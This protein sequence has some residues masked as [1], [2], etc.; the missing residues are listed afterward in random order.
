MTEISKIYE[1]QSVERRWYDFWLKHDCFQA[2]PSRVSARRPAYSIVIPPPN[3]TRVVHSGHVLNNTIQDILARKA[4]MDGREVLWLPGTD[5]AG[6]GTQTVVERALIR[7][8]IMKRR[9]DIGREKFIEYAWAWK[10]KHGG[11]I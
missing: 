9:D 10:E 8:G 2:D 6:I 3:V 1:P 7:Q 11:I 4:R 5:H